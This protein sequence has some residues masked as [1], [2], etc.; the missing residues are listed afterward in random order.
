MHNYSPDL[1]CTLEPDDP[2]SSP[3]LPWVYWFTAS[4][5][6]GLEWLNYIYTPQADMFQSFTTSALSYFTNR[7][8]HNIEKTLI[9]RLVLGFDSFSV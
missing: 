3:S 8:R 7:T 5:R 6:Q 4:V 2:S 9:N 1:Q